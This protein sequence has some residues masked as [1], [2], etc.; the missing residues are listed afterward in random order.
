MVVIDILPFSVLKRPKVFGQEEGY[1]MSQQG[2]C[3]DFERADCGQSGWGRS[4]LDAVVIVSVIA[5]FFV[6]SDGVGPHSSSNDTIRPVKTVTPLRPRAI[7][8]PVAEGCSLAAGKGCGLSSRRSVGGATVALGP[9]VPSG[10][11]PTYGPHP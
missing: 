1:V 7:V 10:L 3:I 5:G 6:I 9:L 2:L 11:Q 8:S 4:L